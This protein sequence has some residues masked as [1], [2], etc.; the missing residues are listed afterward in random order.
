MDGLGSG[1]YIPACGF[2]AKAYHGT[3]LL[4]AASH[5]AEI[6]GEIACCIL[7]CRAPK[8]GVWWCL[9]FRCPGLSYQPVEKCVHRHCNNLTQLHLTSLQIIQYSRTKSSP[10]NHNCWP[11]KANETPQKGGFAP[12]KSIYSIYFWEKFLSTKLINIEQFPWVSA[13]R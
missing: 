8:S 12:L 5:A 10:P 2:C 1:K 4:L 13:L 11:S 7:S 9:A 3:S 6:C